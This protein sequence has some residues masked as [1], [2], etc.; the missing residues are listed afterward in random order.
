[1]NQQTPVHDRLLASGKSLFAELGY[2]GASTSAIARMA[3]TSESQLVRHFGGKAGLLEA[4]FNANWALLNPVMRKKMAAAAN[5]RDAILEVLSVMIDAFGKDHDIAF[6]FLFEG[7][8][9]RG[10]RHEVLLSKGF[11]EFSASLLTLIERGQRDG[12]FVTDIDRAAIL[13]AIMATAEG[14][15]RDRLIAERSGRPLPYS[16]NEI[17]RVVARMMNGLGTG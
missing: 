17:I 16:E 8:R 11:L 5:A 2:E 10:T 13:S 14:M 3:G 4:I 7:R 9:L 6:L 12:S 15:M 1:M